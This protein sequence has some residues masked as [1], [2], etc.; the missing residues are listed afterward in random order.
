MSLSNC[1][2]IP[3][4][5]KKKKKKKN[6]FKQE[7]EG[8]ADPNDKTPVKQSGIGLMS[9]RI[10]IVLEERFQVVVEEATG[11]VNVDRRLSFP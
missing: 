1:S 3:I 4:P 5:F 8:R 11:C 2:C 6:E 9:M 10:R 7:Q